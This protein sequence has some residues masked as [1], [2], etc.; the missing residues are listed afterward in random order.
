MAIANVSYETVCFRQILVLCQE[1]V[2]PNFLAI[3]QGEADYFPE[4]Y[5]K[6]EKGNQSYKQMLPILNCIFRRFGNRTEEIS[7]CPVWDSGAAKG[8][9]AQQ[10]KGLLQFVLS[11][12]GE[13]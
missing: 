5:V 2:Q 6:E 4:R 1:M 10:L 3:C 11:Q 9:L 12:R 7:S 8:S 13:S